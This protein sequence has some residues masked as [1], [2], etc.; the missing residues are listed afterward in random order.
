MYRQFAS[1]ANMDGEYQHSNRRQATSTQSAGHIKQIYCDICNVR[2]TDQNKYFDHISGTL[3][4]RN[5][6]KMNRASGQSRPYATVDDPLLKSCKA[7]GNL[8][9]ETSHEWHAHIESRP[10]C[11]NVLKLYYRMGEAFFAQH[12]G[13][14]DLAFSTEIDKQCS[15]A[16][17]A[18]LDTL[19]RIRSGLLNDFMCK[20]CVVKLTTKSNWTEHVTGR[21][22]KRRG[23]DAMRILGK[24]Q[25]LEKYGDVPMN[26]PMNQQD[27]APRSNIQHDH[28]PATNPK[29][30]QNTMYQEQDVQHATGS[31]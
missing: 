6:E 29:P 28:W 7:C 30:S 3:H 9:F 26:Q 20:V 17:R 22:H 2:F 14:G 27:S 12:H 4:Q 10:H 15:E 31:L 11:E 16:E 19:M 18:D 24:E 23:E 5:R 1:N 8:A 25:Y 21:K 13:G